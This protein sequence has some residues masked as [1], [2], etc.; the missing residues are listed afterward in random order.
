[1]TLGNP[2]RPVGGL[3]VPVPPGVDLR[4]VGREDFGEVMSLV[5]E[6]HARDAG[7]GDVGQRALFE[8]LVNDVDA[9][10]FLAVTN[11]EAAG[12]IVHRLRR[13]LNHAT[14]E[15]WI[16]ELI[17]RQQDRGRS[18][19]RSLLAAVLAEWRL[20]GGHQVEIELRREEVAATGLVEAAGF[21]DHGLFF[22]LT[23][24]RTR[25]IQPA[26]GVVVRPVADDDADFDATTR[27]LAELGRPAPSDEKLPALRRTYV[28][29]VA[30]DD[31]ASMLAE[32]DGT[33]VGFVSL[34]FRHRLGASAPEAWIPDL[35]VTEPARGRDI[36]AALLD[37]AFTEAQS[38]GASAVKLESGAQRRVAHQLYRAAGMVDV[39]SFLTLQR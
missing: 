37:A 33:P 14:F 9:T 27:L 3:A 31:T 17:V 15:G 16:S 13:R 11:G 8:A 28:L 4:P 35:I 20:R 5:R 2:D 34:E 12:L 24:V 29:H 22:E 18:I 26:A 1:V 10:P 7:A 39:G 21:V 38:R 23:P 30:R 36:G 19:G 32:L 6:L 25:E